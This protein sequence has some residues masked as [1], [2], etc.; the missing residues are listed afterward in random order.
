MPPALLSSIQVYMRL[1]ALAQGYYLSCPQP[2]LLYRQ[3]QNS[4]IAVG[5]PRNAWVFFG[6]KFR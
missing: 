3:R 4:A 5:R 2:S 6:R 1:A